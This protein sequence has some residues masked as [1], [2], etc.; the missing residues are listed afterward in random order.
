MAHPA[1]PRSRIS[2]TSGRRTPTG[3]PRPA[4]GHIAR[5]LAFVAV[6]L[7]APTARA[8]Q[9]QKAGYYSPRLGI[10]YDALP[11]QE[12]SAVR[13]LSDPVPGSPLR[14]EQ[15]Q[16]KRG[17]VIVRLDGVPLKGEGDVER[18]HGKT[19]VHYFSGGKGQVQIRYVFLPDMKAPPVPANRDGVV[20]TTAVAGYSPR[21]GIYYGLYRY[22]AALGA[23]LKA[24]PVPGSPCL[25]EQMRLEAGDMITHLNGTPIRGPGDLEARHGKTKVQFVNVRTRRPEVRWVLLPPAED[26]GVPRPGSS[27]PRTQNPPELQ[28]SRPAP[29]RPAPKPK[30]PVE[31]ALGPPPQAASMP[32]A[33]PDEI[34]F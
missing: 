13:L 34:D 19:T 23:R 5:C 11:Y 9:D 14:Q 26:P 24:N 15:I 4:I 2:D 12:A 18:H 1:N 22:G 6:A 30:D 7:A 8:Y 32:A 33:V 16:L 10:Y 21:L 28:A 29:A 20:E 27:R 25:Q 3:R 17:D 31:E